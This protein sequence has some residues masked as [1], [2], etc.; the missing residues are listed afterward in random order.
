M[1]IIRTKL[2]DT[3]KYV[4]KVCTDNENLRNMYN[5]H[6]P[7][8]HDDA[9][10]DLFVENDI[11]VPANAKSFKSPLGVSLELVDDRGK[12]VSYTLVAR[13]SIC[14]TPLRQVSIGII[15]AGYR[16]KLSLIVDNISDEDYF[17]GRHTK[18]AQ[19]CAPD[20]KPIKVIVVDRLS[21]SSRGI[22][23]LGSTSRAKL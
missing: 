9:G 7:A 23:G 14:L 12:N 3:S 19:V 11:L 6:G 2:T 13:S 16:G 21:R 8:Y 20:L 18:L 17:V 22:N 1:N 5:T 15:D 10:I 4:L